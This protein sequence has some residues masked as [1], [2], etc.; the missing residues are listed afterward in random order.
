[1]GKLSTMIAAQSTTRRRF[2]VGSTSA[3]LVMAFAGCDSQ[4]ATEAPAEPADPA[5][6][7]QTAAAQIEAQ[8]F[9]PTIWFKMDPDGVTTVHITKAEMGQHVGTAL[10]RVVADELEVDWEQVRLDHVNTDPK[11]GLMVTGGS[12]SVHTTFMQLSQAG[13]AGRIAL[14]EAGAAMMG[15]A[16]DQC[17]ARNGVVS[18]GDQSVTY[19]EIISSGTIDRTFSPEDLEALPLKDPSERRLLGKPAKAL[20]IP[21]KTRGEAVYGIDAELPGMVYA[22][23]LLPP[24]RYGS[25][26]NGIDDTGAQ[27]VPG[28]RQAIEIKDPSGTCQ[29][30]VAVIADSFAAASK[31]ADA[32]TVDWTPGETAEV[33]EEDILAV[34]RKLADEGTEGA[35]WVDEG[36]TDAALSNAASLVEATYTTG[37]MLHFHLEPVN[38]LATQDEEGVWHVH[39]GNQWQSLILPVLAKALEVGEDKI[40][41]HTYSLGG[42]FGRR[43]YGDYMVP[44]ALTSKALGIPV[45]MVFTREDDS[46]FDCVRSPSV[47]TLR[48]GLDGEGKP[49]GMEH[50]A[51]AGWPT[52]NM[53]SF[54]LAPSTDG[55][56]GQV[57]TFSINGADHWYSVNAHRVRAITNDLANRTFLPGWWRAV[58]PGWTTWAVESFMDEAAHAAGVDPA[59]FRLA[60]L[61]AEGRQAG[62]AP[63]SVG[64]AARQAAVLRKVMEMSG[65]GSADL[66]ADTGMGVASSFGQERTMP[67]WTA[68]C[69]KVKVDRDSGAVTVEK[70]WSAVDAGTLVHPD[71]AL[72]Q[73][74]GA[75]LWGL[76]HVLHEGTRFVDGQVE[77]RNLD[78][79]TPLRMNQVPELEIA[80]IENTEMPVGMGEPPLSVVAPAIAN[81]V[82]NAVG[83]RVRDLPIRPEAVKAAIPT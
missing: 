4:T 13:A 74:E 11:W 27:S 1:M 79:Y 68:C 3:G 22:R 60:L 47:Q 14:I 66:P 49:V 62:S 44:A 42:G 48:M 78:R 18:A 29:G 82:F 12:W 41:L 34:G 37:T 19:A 54:F 52:L 5:P 17:T 64:G 59:A 50:N 28:Y 16:P 63:N 55:T 20:D 71:G 70:L 31:A 26:V 43:L 65:Y 51:C 46:R 10:A 61:D 9:E 80:F 76:S 53:A 40:V 24:T 38:A 73:A 58:G 57:D 2:L 25:T 33:T 7:P 69:A 8:A 45:K 81:A 21:A 39:S 75:T 83:A 77:A 6:A 67:T 15:V 72:A 32:I 36:D 56:E 30:W 23:P 35:L